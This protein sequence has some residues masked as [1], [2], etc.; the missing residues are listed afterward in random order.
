MTATQHPPTDH[1]KTASESG[2]RRYA[3]VNPFTGQT[4]TTFDYTPTPP[5]STSFYQ[6]YDATRLSYAHPTKAY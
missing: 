4:E 2:E 3:T 6:E 5:C 1:P